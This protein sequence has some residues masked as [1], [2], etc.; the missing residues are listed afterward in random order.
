[1]DKIVLIIHG[2]PQP[3][4][5]EHFLYPYLLARGYEI[6]APSLFDSENAFT[7]REILQNIKNQLH[8]KKPDV[9]VGISLGGLILPLVAREYSEAKLIFIASA[10]SLRAK[11]F[12]FN[13]LLKIKKSRLAPKIFNSV[14]PLSKKTLRSFYRLVSPFIG[15]SGQRQFYEED[16]RRNIDYLKAIPLNKHL[17]IIEFAATINNT[18]ILEK[19][20]NR[21][22][23]FCGEKDLLMPLAKGKELH[24]LLK[25]SGL[26]VTENGHFNVFSKRNLPALDSF[27]S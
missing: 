22:L 1:M 19:M 26:I 4:S 23:I 27:L 7:L 5:Q 17:E 16:M 15:S 3:F 13:T 24:K 18:S 25:N 9:I 14:Q 2:W 21:A 10:A 11:S 12:I 6:I 8:G 20:E